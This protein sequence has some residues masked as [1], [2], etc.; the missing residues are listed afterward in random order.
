MSLYHTTP[1]ARL[2]L[3]VTAGTTALVV[4]VLADWV[5]QTGT[6][7]YGVGV[8]IDGVYSTE[9]VTVANGVTQFTVNLDGAAHNI[10]LANSY[11]QFIYGAFVYSYSATGGTATVRGVTLPSTKW[12]IYGDS[13]ATGAYATILPKECWAARLQNLL[14][15][16]AVSLEAFGGRGLFTDQG[17]DPTQL[18]FGGLGSQA[19]LVTRF[20]RHLAGATTK[21]VIMMIGVNDALY[22]GGLWSAAGY[23]AA[24]GSL[25]DAIRVAD[26]TIHVYLFSPIITGEEAA[27]NNFGNVVPDY[28]TQCSTAA[29]SRT[30][31]VTFTDGTTLMTI[32]GLSTGAGDGVV[33]PGTL[34]HQSIFDGTGGFGG[35]TNVRAVLGV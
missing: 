11:V 9:L 33:H 29:S 32:G 17:T 2:P 27:V 31:F 24:L 20:Q 14:P 21:N 8:Y 22:N 16:G 6:P 5:G 35:A 18:G 30:G 34:G 4:N 23:G 19:N 1:L 25:L 3:R 26:P 10:D 7:D 15:L 13:I 12:V 28:R